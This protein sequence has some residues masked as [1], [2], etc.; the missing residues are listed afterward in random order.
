MTPETPSASAANDGTATMSMSFV[1][2]QSL[3]CFEPAIPVAILNGRPVLALPARDD[4]DESLAEL[5]PGEEVPLVER[6]G[7]AEE[8]TL[9][10]CVEDEFAVAAR[11]GG[12]ALHVDDGLAHRFGVFEAAFAT[13]IIESRVTIRDSS[14]SVSPS[15]PAGR[16][17]STM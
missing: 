7:H 13:P 3:Q 14:C 11:R 16:S 10:R 12:R 17:G 15:V 8:A 2:E 1:G 9:P 4:R 6:H 5:V